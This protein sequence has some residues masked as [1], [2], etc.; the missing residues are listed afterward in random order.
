MDRWA[1]GPTLDGRFS[2]MSTDITPLEQAVRSTL[3]PA[4]LMIRHITSNNTE[5]ELLTS[6]SPT[7][8]GWHGLSCLSRM[9][10]LQYQF[11]ISVSVLTP[12]TSLIL[13]Q[14]RSLGSAPCQD[15]SSGSQVLPFVRRTSASRLL[16]TAVVM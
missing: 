5:W 13:E 1:G 16:P 3:V 14:K 8:L 7:W 2:K 6:A 10:Q 9:V 4:I 12:L 15:C 11:K